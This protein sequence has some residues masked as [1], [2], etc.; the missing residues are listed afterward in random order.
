MWTGS[1]LGSFV[2]SPLIGC[3]WLRPLPTAKASRLLVGSL[4]P[5]PCPAGGKKLHKLS[6]PLLVE[7]A[8]GNS[9]GITSF[10]LSRIGKIS[11]GRFLAGSRTPSSLRHARKVGCAFFHPFE[12]C[13]AE[14]CLAF[15]LDSRAN[16]TME[17]LPSSKMHKLLLKGIGSLPCCLGHFN[18]GLYSI[19]N[20]QG[21]HLRLLVAPKIQTSLDSFSPPHVP[22]P[23][24]IGIRPSSASNLNFRAKPEEGSRIDIADNEKPYVWP[25]LFLSLARKRTQGNR[26]T[27]PKETT[28]TGQPESTSGA[29]P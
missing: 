2:E 15:R 19:Q 10:Q 9:A 27:C 26:H 23:H 28:R 25:D 1:I 13:I 20:L 7:A 12:S 11:E 4:P 17:G 3:A 24:C 5:V 16:G 6:G 14:I 8:L 18:F 21:S 29:E 22:P